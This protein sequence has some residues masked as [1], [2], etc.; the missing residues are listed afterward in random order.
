M[1]SFKT[2]FTILTGIW[3]LFY[4]TSSFPCRLSVIIYELIVTK[5]CWCG[6][7]CLNYL[8][9]FTTCWLA[10][11]LT[12]TVWERIQQRYFCQ[13]ELAPWVSLFIERG[14]ENLG[15][16]LTCLVSYSFLMLS[17]VLFRVLKAWWHS[18]HMYTYFLAPNDRHSHWCCTCLI[19]WL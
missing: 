9:H 16:V 15:N 10:K 11:K 6:C 2:L 13:R 14:E 7:M 5:T 18:C 3:C 12:R 4:K 17:S 1:L 8:M 19:S